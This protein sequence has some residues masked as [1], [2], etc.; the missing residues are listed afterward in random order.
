MTIRQ[1]NEADIDTLVTLLR[2]SFSD[3]AERFELTIENC[4]KNLAFCTKERVKSDLDRGLRYYILEGDG[5]PCGCAAI[6]KAG[7]DVCY[8]ER[9]AVLP[10]YRRK[11][12]GKALVNHIFDQAGKNGAQKVEI[13]IISEDTKLKNWYS[14]FGFVQKSTKKFDHLPFIVAFMSAEMDDTNQTEKI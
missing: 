5:R 12:Y 9:L 6:E 8:L 1:A 7:P 3:V 11:G 2:S 14:Q 4:P 13:G 10:Q